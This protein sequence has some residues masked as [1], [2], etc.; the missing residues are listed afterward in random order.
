MK[1]KLEEYFLVEMMWAISLTKENF[2][3]EL[4]LILLRS[5][6]LSFFNHLIEELGRSYYCFLF[7]YLLELYDFEDFDDFDDLEDSLSSLS[8]FIID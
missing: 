7:I 6:T 3:T 2:L 1:N 5:L 4:F 8:S